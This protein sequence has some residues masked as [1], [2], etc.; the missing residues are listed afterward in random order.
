MEFRYQKAIVY[1][2][3]HAAVSHVS[4]SDS[5]PGQGAPVPTGSGAVHVLLFDLVPGPQLA[6]Q[7]VQELHSDQPPSTPVGSTSVG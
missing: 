6:E 1:I 5:S 2:P 7:S 4:S 3:G